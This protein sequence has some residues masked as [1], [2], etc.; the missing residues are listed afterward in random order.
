MRWF[1]SFFNQENNLQVKL[2]RLRVTSF[3]RCFFFHYDKIFLQG[4]VYFLKHKNAFS[5]RYKRST[6]ISFNSNIFSKV[7]GVNFLSTKRKLFFVAT[8]SRV[9]RTFSSW[10][11]EWVF[12]EWWWH[13]KLFWTV[14]LVNREWRNVWVES[15]SSR[16][17]SVFCHIPAR[18]KSV[19]LPLQ[20]WDKYT[21]TN[22]HTLQTSA[23]LKPASCVK[24]ITEA[25]ASVWPE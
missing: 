9:L 13:W 7:T 17:V 12:S 23:K 19:R 14:R 1:F 15:E 20:T 11:C 24:L 16:N 3:E 18:S 8:V 25:T 21:D 5:I 4:E 2:S 10:V 6:F 22:L